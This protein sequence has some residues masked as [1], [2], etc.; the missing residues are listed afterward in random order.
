MKTQNVTLS[1]PK[2][3]LR[4]AKLLAIKRKTSLSTLLANTLA[5]V[6]EHEEGFE[7]ARRRNIEFLK[8]GIDMGGLDKR[9][10]SRDD[11]HER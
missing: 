6:V 7:E 1:L 2:E 3:I 4:K 8:R 9:N 11:L 10:W 5:E